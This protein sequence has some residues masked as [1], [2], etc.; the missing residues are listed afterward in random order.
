MS[1]RIENHQPVPLVPLD[2]LDFED[3]EPVYLGSIYDKNSTC[4]RWKSESN[5]NGYERVGENLWVFKWGDQWFDLERLEDINR[6]PCYLL[7][8]GRVMQP[9]EKVVVEYE[10]YYPAT[11]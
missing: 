5:P 3:G 8:L 9:G 11:D 10:R 4:S 7:S 1:I 2:Q 6:D